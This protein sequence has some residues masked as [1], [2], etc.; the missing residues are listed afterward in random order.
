MTPRIAL[1]IL[2]LSQM[3]GLSQGFRSRSFSAGALDQAARFIYETPGYPHH[4]LAGGVITDTL[5]GQ[6]VLRLGIMGLDQDGKVLWQK[7]YG[8][9]TH[10]YY[11]HPFIRRSFYK[12]ENFI[13]TACYTADTNGTLIG[14]LVKFDLDGD[15]LWQRFYRD[16]D[17]W[18]R[19]IPQ[20]VTGAVDGG[21]LITGYFL[22]E[23]LNPYQQVILIKTDAQGQELW[24][25]KIPLLNSNMQEGRAILQDSASRKIVIV[26]S[27][28]LNGIKSYD[29]VLILDS[30]GQII[31]RLRYLDSEGALTDLIQTRDK[32]LV[33]TGVKAYN[34]F[35]GQYYLYQGF[36]VKL[37]LHQPSHPLW[38]INGYGPKTR[39]NNFTCLY[40]MENGDLMI[41]GD[42]D[43]FQ[44][45]NM[46]PNQYHRLTQVNPNGQIKWS[47]L[48]DYR[49]ENSALPNYYKT[50][51]SL[52]P[53]SNGSILASFQLYNP[54]TNP[55]FFVKYDSLG[56]D[57]TLDYCT[58]LLAG[59]GTD[60]IP[61]SQLR[62]YPNPAR[63]QVTIETDLGRPASLIISDV[64]GREVKRLVIEPGKTR[65]DLQELSPGLY[66]LNRPGEVPLRLIK[67]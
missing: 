13:Y 28:Y 39:N 34:Q 37:D 31:Q 63:E 66:F 59:L 1:L 6:Y 41:G 46:A 62:L 56:C 53:G 11:H 24:R 38:T 40:E 2:L 60:L 8:D 19:V 55:F 16:P 15:T 10:Q 61:S 23:G 47:R 30:L 18:G 9:K 48:Y 44:V 29:H 36:A 42:L 25:K 45:L 32:H 5:D 50:N 33:A 57:S 17:P 12:Q 64:S 54:G 35:N 51:T 22:D 20:M 43:T 4:Y 52:Q 21:F 58:A 26:G 67:E 65:I 7:K 14:T 27:Q 3:S 49:P